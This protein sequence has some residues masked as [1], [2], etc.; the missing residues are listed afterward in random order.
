M[1]TSKTIQPVSTKSFI[2]GNLT[3]TAFIVVVV[4]F[5]I[6]AFY[7]IAS[8]ADF[9]TY[10]NV[11]WQSTD[12]TSGGSDVIFQA[13]GEEGK[14]LIKDISISGYSKGNAN[15]FIRIEC[16]DSNEDLILLAPTVNYDVW[17]K[18]ETHYEINKWCNT[19]DGYASLLQYDFGEGMDA[20]AINIQTHIQGSTSTTS[21]DPSDTLANNSA[22][23]TGGIVIIGSI[24]GADLVRRIFYKPKK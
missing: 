1:M 15:D 20:I 16:T 2:V 22:W 13:A 18:W 6:G 24:A 10:Q 7:S 4:F 21:Q 14:W 17:L 5:L 23:T 11:L 9:N 3:A 12:V 19:T 8:G